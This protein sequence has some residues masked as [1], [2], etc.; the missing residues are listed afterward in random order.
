MASMSV[1]VHLKQF[2]VHLWT[3]CQKLDIVQTACAEGVK[4]SLL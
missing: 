2:M 1:S 3:L 4:F